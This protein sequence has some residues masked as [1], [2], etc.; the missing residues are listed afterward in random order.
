LLILKIKKMAKAKAKAKDATIDETI[1]VVVAEEVTPV[2]LNVAVPEK[3][4]PGNASRA[5][6]G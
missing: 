1:V 6:R 2:L 4:A 5:F 3:E